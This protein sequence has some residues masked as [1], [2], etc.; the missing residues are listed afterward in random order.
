MIPVIARM[1]MFSMLFDERPFGKKGSGHTKPINPTSLGIQPEK[2]CRI[3]KPGYL[4][5]IMCP[6]KR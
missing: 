6:E 4:T 3:I 1:P 2:E 5:E